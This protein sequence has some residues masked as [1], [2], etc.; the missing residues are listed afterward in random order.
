MTHD[1]RLPFQ[2]RNLP[3]GVGATLRAAREGLG[4]TRRAVASAVGIAPRTLARIERGAQ[5]PSWSTLDRLCDH[6][7]V[8]VAALATRWLR[9]S[10]DLPTNPEASPGIGLRALRRQ[11]GMTLVELAGL[12]GISAATISRFERGLT[13]SR[14]LASRVGGPDVDPDERD[15]VLD[16]AA[17]VGALGFADVAALRSACLKAFNDQEAG[18]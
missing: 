2:R 7:G 1:F 14:R 4:R 8:S 9:D 10:L 13:A 15:V 16:S 6:L 11:R 12:S 3:E 5:K 17:L 18:V